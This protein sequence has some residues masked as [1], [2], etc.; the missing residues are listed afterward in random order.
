[1]KVK[2]ERGQR[3]CGFQSW[4]R[5]SDTLSSVPNDLMISIRCVKYGKHTKCAML[6]LS[7]IRIENH[8]IEASSGTEMGG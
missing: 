7:G 1:M 8:W 2:R 4:S 5:R 3:R 6:W